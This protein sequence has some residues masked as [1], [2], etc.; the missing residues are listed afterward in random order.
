MF[1]LL[2][3]DFHY[4]NKMEDYGGVLEL[5]ILLLY[6]STGNCY[7]NGRFGLYRYMVEHRLGKT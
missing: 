2:H 3:F 6:K 7:D 5:P 1:L 4:F